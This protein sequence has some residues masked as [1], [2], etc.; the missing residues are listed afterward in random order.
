MLIL[1]RRHDPL[2]LC[3]LWLLYMWLTAAMLAAGCWPGEAASVHYPAAPNRPPS[4]AAAGQTGRRCGRG[5]VG[6]VPSKSWHAKITLWTLETQC[7]R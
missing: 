4:R 6:W 2:A 7:Q 1:R 3:S 5:M